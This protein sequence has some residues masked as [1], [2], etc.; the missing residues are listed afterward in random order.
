MW[1]VYILKSKVSKFKYTGSTNNIYRRLKE[2]NNGL[3]QAT[4]HY[5][6]FALWAYIA[7]SDKNIAINLED[8][9]KTGSGSAFVSKRLL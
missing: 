4:K 6:P 9:F 1:Y 8:Y 2:H 3:C 7:V 5:K